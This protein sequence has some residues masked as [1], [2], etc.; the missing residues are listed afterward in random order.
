MPVFARTAAGSLI[1]LAFTNVR[2]VPTFQYTLLSVDQIWAEQRVDARFADL[3]H[4]QLPESSGGH[5]I[6]YDR[7][8][9][10]STLVLVSAIASPDSLGRM[11]PR[12]HVAKSP[13]Q[14]K[15][16]TALL[17]F[18][19]LKSTAHIAKLSAAQAGELMHRRRHQG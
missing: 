13:A 12:C 2:C 18:H 5:V 4:L 14:G 17:G 1:R 19:S 16:H 11:A 10:L 8:L 15:N 6:P 3:R 7:S 9:K